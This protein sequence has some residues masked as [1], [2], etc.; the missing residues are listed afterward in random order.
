MSEKKQFDAVEL[1]R[2]LRD[3]VSTVIES[4]S[5][6]EQLARLNRPLSDP[7]LEKLR[8]R[9]A[10]PAAAADAPQTARG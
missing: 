2:S 9:A 4:L 1:M 7:A 5:P 8:R 3:R 10:Q 6:E